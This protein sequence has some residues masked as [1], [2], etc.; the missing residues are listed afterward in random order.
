[1]PSL[2]RK[3]KFLVNIVE[4]KLQETVLY[5]TKRDAQLERFIAPSVPT[6]VYMR[7]DVTGGGGGG[8]GDPM[9]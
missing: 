6:V 1:M 3:K 2:I 4:P 7:A 9:Y 8:V 5:G